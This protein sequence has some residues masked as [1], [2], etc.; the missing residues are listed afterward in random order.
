VSE[1]LTDKL[2]RCLAGPCDFPREDA[3]LADSVVSNLVF[4]AYQGDVDA[5]RLIFE[6]VDRPVAREIAHTKPGWPFKQGGLHKD[7]DKLAAD[8]Y[9]E[10]EA[11]TAEQT[12][13]WRQTAAEIAE[14]KRERDEAIGYTRG[15]A[16][17][18]FRRPELPPSVYEKGVTDGTFVLPNE[19]IDAGDIR[20][21]P[22]SGTAAHSRESD[23][24]CDAHPRQGER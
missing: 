1:T 22:M 24:L 18:G 8:Y 7:A 9:A 19:P 2:L 5:A 12:S 17:G 10:R 20:S 14:S 3:T 4:R 21:T 15:Y 13:S 11:K 16:P 6:L 23:A